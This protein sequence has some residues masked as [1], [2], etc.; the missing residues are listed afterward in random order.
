MKIYKIKLEDKIAFLNR[1]DKLGVKIKTSQIKNDIVDEPH[2]F[3]ITFSNEEDIE[4]VETVL[5]QSP[6]IN[7][8][9]ELLRK[10]VREE[11]KK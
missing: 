8:L 11:L 9:K 3:T 7:Q 2:S 10:L 1:L 6:K 4:K 5:D